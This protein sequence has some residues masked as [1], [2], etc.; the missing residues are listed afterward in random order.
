MVTVT[1]LI[2]T[3]AVASNPLQCLPYEDRRTIAFTNGWALSLAFSQFRDI[4]DSFNTLKK[5]D[6]RQL[7]EDL[8]EVDF[9]EFT[10]ISNLQISCVIAD[11]MERYQVTQ[12]KDDVYN[13]K[14]AKFVLQ[15]TSTMLRVLRELLLG[16]YEANYSDKV[17][18]DIGGFQGE[19]AV[20]FW[21]HGAKKIVIYE[22]VSEY[23][24]Y[25]KNNITSNHI[26]AEI[27]QSGIGEEEGSMLVDIF[28]QRVNDGAVAVKELIKIRNIADII[29]Q[30][31][32]D[33]AKIDCEG[34]EISLTT[35]PN[36]IL[37]KIPCY[38]LELHGE[39]TCK[40]VTAK[41]VKAGFKVTKTIRRSDY[42]SIAYFYLLNSS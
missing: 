29:N 24:Q 14:V 27:H 42:L 19:S 38:M 41:F 31:N 30:S 5:Y 13:I 17:V 8:F 22:P 11:L 20:Y 4:R 40:A 25:I 21:M 12:I 7:D 26:D 9:G 35:V 34:A 1:G 3:F 39:A 32:A 36:E 10:T 15:G 33:I 18:L 2:R 16:E 28:D 37:R 23:C 6:V